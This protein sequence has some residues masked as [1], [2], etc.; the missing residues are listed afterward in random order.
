MMQAIPQQQ[1]GW[2]ILWSHIARNHL[3]GVINCFKKLLAVLE[4]KY[5][6]PDRLLQ[7]DWLFCLQKGVGQVLSI[8]IFQSSPTSQYTESKLTRGCP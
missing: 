7:L 1:Q 3:S 4:S 2:A 6:Q 8:L 5:P